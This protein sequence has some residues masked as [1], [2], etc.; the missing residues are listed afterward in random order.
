MRSGKVAVVGGSLIWTQPTII[1]D[2][3][4]RVRE[5]GLFI[6]TVST[7]SALSSMTT[8]SPWMVTMLLAICGGGLL[9]YLSRVRHWTQHDIMTLALGL[10]LLTAPYLWPYDFVLLLPLAIIIL[11][12]NDGRSSNRTAH[13]LLLSSNFVMFFLHSTTEDWTSPTLIFYPLLLVTLFFLRT[14]KR[15]LSAT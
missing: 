4:N 2:Y 13:Y 14:N 1:F 7:P 8:A 9:L 6:I 3:I 12:E 10:S 15:Y 11:I 5:S